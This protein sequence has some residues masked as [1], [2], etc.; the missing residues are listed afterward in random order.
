MGKQIDLLRKLIKEELEIALNEANEKDTQKIHSINA[1]GHAGS[2][3]YDQIIYVAVDSSEEAEE[4]AKRE[5]ERMYD[6]YEISDIKPISTYGDLDSDEQDLFKGN[7]AIFDADV[8]RGEDLNETD[9][10]VVEESISDV[11][12]YLFTDEGDVE[13]LEEAQG[14]GSDRMTLKK[15]MS[16]ED[17]LSFLKKVKKDAEDRKAKTGRYS[18]PKHKPKTVTRKIFSDEDIEMLADIVSQPDGFTM[19]DI[20]K[21]PFYADSKDPR[22]AAQKFK[23]V[24]GIEKK[25]G[26][27]KDGS[28]LTVGKDLVDFTGVDD[29]VSKPKS[30]EDKEVENTDSENTDSEDV[31]A[32]EFEDAKDGKIDGPTDE[33]LAGI[34][35][36][37]DDYIDLNEDLVRMFQK[38]A[39]LLNG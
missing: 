4:I 28:Y 14:R 30:P 1:V 7:V 32:D 23:D 36:E 29:T 2:T 17:A 12:D 6:K 37:L 33:E 31:D 21:M 11:V 18:D 26:L 15:G 10:I 20:V 22:R 25:V 34:E 24:L 9:E 27:A 35:D 16:K 19:A 39:G 8:L 38:R 3:R 5:L 13:E